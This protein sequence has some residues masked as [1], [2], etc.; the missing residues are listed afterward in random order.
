MWLE[1]LGVIIVILIGIQVYF[2]IADR[3]NI[4]DKPN[5]RS[6]H[7]SITIRG[8]GI[9][10]P[11][12]LFLWNL[13]HQSPY[14]YLT[15]GILFIA[16]ISFLDDILTLPN[17]PRILVHFLSVVLVLFQLNF[18]SYPFWIWIIGII[19]VIGWLN[20]FNFMDGINGITAMYAVS[21]LLPLAYLNLDYSI[22]NQGLYYYLFISLAVFGFYNIRKIAKTFA[23][24]VGS[25]SLGLI[26]AFLVIGLILKTG[27]W[28]YIMFVSVYGI[29][30]VLTIVQRLLNK[31]NIFQ[32]HRSHLY[33]LLA[34]E[35]N[36]CHICVSLSYASFQLSISAGV[37]MLRNNPLVNIYS[38]ILLALLIIFYVLLKR[39][40]YKGIEVV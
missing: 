27:Q 23:G 17:R 11:F 10:F 36:M 28:F 26:I 29:D 32:A 35:K 19:L 18:I 7:S 15:L 8:G 34:N 40:I 38:S 20:T 9:V 5:D 22:V 6:S 21:V 3:Y 2:I 1:W 12:A 14:P 31:E 37:I 13:V 39:R 16:T 24:D 25:I 30:S 4:I 33:Q